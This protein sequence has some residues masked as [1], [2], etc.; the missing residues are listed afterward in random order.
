MLTYAFHLVEAFVDH[1]EGA[2][3]QLLLGLQAQAVSYYTSTTVKCA[4]TLLRAGG[5]PGGAGLRLTSPSAGGC[6]RA[7]VG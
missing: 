4:N 3:P 1:L 7:P 5:R 2:L 6:F